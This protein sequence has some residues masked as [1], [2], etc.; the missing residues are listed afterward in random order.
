MAPSFLSLITTS[1][2]VTPTSLLWASKPWASTSQTSTCAWTRWLMSSTTPRSLW[3]PH[4]PWSTY[5]SESYQPVGG[6][7]RR[8]QWY[9][10]TYGTVLYMYVCLYVLV[11]LYVRV[12]TYTLYVRVHVHVLEHVHVCLPR[13]SDVIIFQW[14][15]W[16]RINYYTVC[17]AYCK[18]TCILLQLIRF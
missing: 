5:A 2:H 18:C 9:I 16:E 11:N 15:S 13:L 14:K 6:R 7:G 1:P 10:Y 12:Y 4:A 17:I 3:S 8:C